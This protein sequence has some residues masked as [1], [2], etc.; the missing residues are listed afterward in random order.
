MREYIEDVELLMLEN[1]DSNRLTEREQSKR[2]QKKR[3][4]LVKDISKD[5]KS[6]QEKQRKMKK[7]EHDNQE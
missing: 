6:V 5:R 2:I 4:K 7:N 1:R 3:D